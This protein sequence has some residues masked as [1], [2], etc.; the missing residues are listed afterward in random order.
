VIEVGTVIGGR[1]RI[2]QLLGQGGMGVVAAATHLELG[3]R[4]AV[5]VMR[6]ELAQSPTIVERFIREARAVVQLRTEHVCRVLDVGRLDSGAPYIMMELLEGADLARAI[7]QRPLPVPIA[8]EYVV[9][10][11]VA[12]AEAHGAG[13][14]HRDLKP[15]NLF[16]TRRRDGGPL[17]KV[18]DFGIAKA[19]TSDAHL[20]QGSSIL[21]SPGF[22]SPE[23]LQS[24]SDVDARTDIWALGVTLYQLITGRLPFFGTNPSEVAIK[25][26][27][28][29]PAPLEVEPALAAVVMRCLAKPLAQRYPDVQTLV[30][31]L[32]RFGGAGATRA[33]GELRGP[34][35]AAVMAPAPMI[36]GTAATAAGTAA[37]TSGTAATAAGTAAPMS[38]AAGHAP[39]SR[40]PSTVPAAP[41]SRAW[42]WIV[43]AAILAAGGATAAIVIARDRAPAVAASPPHDG[44]KVVVATVP[45]P[46]AAPPPPPDAA[47]PPPPD[48]SPPPDAEATVKVPPGV[49]AGI[50]TPMKAGTDAMQKN[51]RLMVANSMFAKISPETVTWCWCVLGDAVHAQESVAKVPA[52]KRKA[53]VDNCKGMH[54]TVTP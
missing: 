31:D 46:D 30:A 2:D 41:H 9:Q 8:V 25:I 10:A 32:A 22:M 12:L 19:M 24:P 48:A 37:P 28:D 49:P 52:K 18:L 36:S 17:V 27:N 50:A 6:D 35:L 45:P 16:V 53:V 1:L 11:C 40:A 15:A 34:H 44:A 33:A 3:H 26:A 29:P 51:C 39:M 21:G 7:A 47:P 13:I 4:V 5:K 54:V 38:S 14:I 23:Q 42:I 43:V 20:T